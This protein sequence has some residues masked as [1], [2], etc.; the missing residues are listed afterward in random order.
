M[1]FR[2]QFRAFF[3]QCLNVSLQCQDVRIWKQQM[4]DFME[5]GF[6]VGGEKIVH[7]AIGNNIRMQKSS[8]FGG[9]DLSQQGRASAKCIFFNSKH[10]FKI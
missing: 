10:I 3:L 8:Q 9:S 6:P 5:R 2:L 4:M 1:K 7:R